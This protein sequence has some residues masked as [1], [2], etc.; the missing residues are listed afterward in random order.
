MELDNILIFGG[1]GSIG[2]AFTDFYVKKSVK[3][4]HV[5]SRQ[6]VADQFAAVNYH[7]LDFTNEESLASAA[8]QVADF[9]SVD[10]IIVA[11]GLLHN[12][13]FRPEKSLRE[14]SSSTL[15]TTMN[16]NVV[17]PALIAKHFIPLLNKNDRSVFAALSARVGSISDNRMGGWYSYRA[18][19]AALN[20][21]I[22]TL[23]IEV[24]RTKKKSIVV[25]LHPGTVKSELSRPFQ[26]NVPPA[27]LFTP[28]YSVEKMHTVISGLELSDNGKIL[29][30]DGDE[31][32]P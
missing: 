15:S 3:N 19:K 27:K 1:T 11:I 30:W 28:E 32:M 4:I 6:S 21:I 18:S 25:G 13:D 10:L 8:K 23:S 29:A 26:A 31:V 9:G 2:R 22:K 7:N 16:S 5:F 17:V 12:S 14:I 20:M 24:S